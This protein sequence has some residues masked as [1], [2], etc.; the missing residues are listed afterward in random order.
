MVKM[1]RYNTPP[2][3]AL[4]GWWETGAAS[5]GYYQ[6]RLRKDLSD[7]NKLFFFFFQR[8]PVMDILPEGV[9][10]AQ[11]PSRA[12]WKRVKVERG[13]KPLHA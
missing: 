13:K 2:L 12:C 6:P 7:S 8:I 9:S 4:L 1:N 5:R 10:E 3:S 11:R